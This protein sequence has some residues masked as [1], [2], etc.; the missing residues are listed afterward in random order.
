MMQSCTAKFRFQHRLG[1]AV[2]L[3]CIVSL[4]VST[5]PQLLSEFH[6][7]RGSLELLWDQLAIGQNSTPGESDFRQSTG[8]WTCGGTRAICVLG[9]SHWLKGN[10]QAAFEAL[11]D[12]CSHTRCS[13]VDALM[14]GLAF[15]RLG[16]HAK[17]VTVWQTVQAGSYFLTR[18]RVLFAEGDYSGAEVL[19]RQAVEIDSELLDAWYALAQVYYAMNRFRDAGQAYLHAA[20]LEPADTADRLFAEARGYWYSD[21]IDAAINAFSEALNS[22]VTNDPAAYYEL[23]MLWLHAKNNPAQAL[24]IFTQ[25][26]V[27]YPRYGWV[28][29]GAGDAA[30]MLDRK[31]DAA[32]YYEAALLLM[33]GQVEL[34]QKLRTLRTRIFQP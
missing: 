7:N 10:A 11:A 4:A 9:R 24:D 3:V 23:G 6:I 12:C 25:G 28:Y 19:L 27:R 21:E 32:R 2:S 33:P 20:S 17:A 22:G 18:G 26:I 8:W 1:F 16:Q 5:L 31:T 30:D 15:D 13:A 34:Q 29:S 14:L